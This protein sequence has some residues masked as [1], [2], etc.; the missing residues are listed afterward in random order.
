VHIVSGRSTEGRRLVDDLKN[1]FEAVIPGFHGLL[2]SGLGLE[3]D[4]PE[5]NCVGYFII[6][7]SWD[8]AWSE[9]RD[10][11]SVELRNKWDTIWH[12]VHRLLVAEAYSSIFQF[13][14]PDTI[15][16]FDSRVVRRTES[17]VPYSFCGFFHLDTG[18]V[19]YSISSISE[20]AYPAE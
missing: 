7:G 16:T 13:P 4:E 19:S 6:L 9:S 10:L 3:P 18:N 8:A 14:L 2:K 1:D 15:V 17:G 5:D 20:C 12:F 11:T